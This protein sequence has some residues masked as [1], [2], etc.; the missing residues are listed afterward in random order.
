M[1]YSP[2]LKQAALAL[3]ALL[4]TTATAAADPSREHPGIGTLHFDTPGLSA[5]RL[6][7][8]IRVDVTG[9]V[10]RTRMQQE[11]RNPSDAWVSA[12]YLLPLPVGAAV[13]QL[14]MTVGEQRIVGEIQRKA[15]AEQTFRAAEAS[16]RQAALV[17]RTRPNLF[18]TAVANIPPHGEVRIAIEYQETL[19]RDADR[20][21]LRLPLTL[22]PRYIPGQPVESP[23]D[24]LGN[25]WAPATDVVADAPRLTPA[26]A[27]TAPPDSHRLTLEIHLATG[28]ALAEIVSHHHRIDVTDNG[29]GRYEIRLADADVPLDHDFELRW[30]PQ[31][32]EAA[33]L[34][35]FRHTADDG[36]Y[37]ALQLLPPGQPL[38]TAAPRELIL[39]IDTSGSMHGVS[40]EQAKS[41]LAV[42]IGSLRPVDQFNVIAFNNQPQALFRTAVAADLANR[43]RAQS[44]VSA[45]EANGGTEMHAAL[46]QALQ[47]GASDRLRQVIF[48]TDGAVGDEERLF[49]LIEQR[50][51]EDRL[52]TVGIGSAPNG[53]FMRKAAELGR[54]QAITISALADVNERMTDLF[55]RLDAPTLTDVTIDWQ[56]TTVTQYP[57]TVPDLYAGEPIALSA[58]ATELPKSVTVKATAWRDGV[59]SPWSRTVSLAGAPKGGRAVSVNWANDAIES[60]GDQQRRGVLSRDAASEAI[61]SLALAHHL[62]SRETSLVAVARTPARPANAPLSAT[63][64]PNLVPYGQ[65]VP[66]GQLVSTATP[67]PLQRLLGVLSLLAALAGLAASRWQSL[68]AA[69]RA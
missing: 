69:V 27:R 10:A 12:T 38:G 52:F 25:G 57:K 13:D 24:R 34:S 20:F 28:T 3:A 44:W 55:A 26:M 14:D 6:A 17:S 48:V 4:L 42:A 53:W 46:Q 56:G 2:V 32:A 8:D 29:P 35:V 68:T 66:L 39:V 22:T 30:R 40:I 7:T 67:A 63:Q 60:F 19:D 15:K 18:T 41:A 65:R 1:Q 54:G 16:G 50:L 36:E 11:F 9:H 58:H 59:P 51:G 23:P 49:A 21:T 43:E 33:A 45:L 5:V 31:V 62:V 37:A 61:A 47:P 64:V